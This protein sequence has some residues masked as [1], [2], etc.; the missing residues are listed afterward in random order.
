MK[1]VK[2]ARSLLSS[3][4]TIVALSATAKTGS[5]YALDSNESYG[6]ITVVVSSVDYSSEVTR[7]KGALKGEP[8]TSNRIDELML[9]A[10]SGDVY[11]AI[12]IDGID[13]NRYFQ[14][15]GNGLIDVEIDFSPLEKMPFFNL[16]MKGPKGESNSRI[17]KTT[18]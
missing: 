10:P 12:D 17:L 6:L 3:L 7:V 13:M 16:L 9:I 14:W 18:R 1:Y 5:G 2:S 8:N 4:L 15:E 11:H